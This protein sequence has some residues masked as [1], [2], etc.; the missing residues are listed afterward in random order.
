MIASALSIRSIAAIDGT[1]GAVVSISSSTTHPHM[2]ATIFCPQSGQVGPRSRGGGC[3][4]RWSTGVAAKGN[5]ASVRV[6]VARPQPHALAIFRP[7]Q[8][9]RA[10]IR[11]ARIF[12]EGMVGRP[13]GLGRFIGGTTF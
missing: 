8:P 2:P 7:D 6:T 11:M 10:S 3:G 4:G 9:S 5:R 1:N 13:L 12:C